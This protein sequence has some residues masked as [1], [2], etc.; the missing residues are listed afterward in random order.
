MNEKFEQLLRVLEQ[1][2][3][4]SG[5]EPPIPEDGQQVGACVNGR[6]VEVLSR[7]I[8]VLTQ[9]LSERSCASSTPSEV[10]VEQVETVWAS[11]ATASACIV[12]SPTSQDASSHSTRASTVENVSPMSSAQASA[13]AAASLGVAST[14]ANGSSIPT[15]HMGVPVHGGT[16]MVMPP[17]F[18]L[19][20][21]LPTGAPGAP[22]NPSSQPIF[23]A[24]P[25]YVPGQG[26]LC[27]GSETNP[28]P[29]PSQVQV[30]QP[31]APPTQPASEELKEIST[32][33]SSG[34]ELAKEGWPTPGVSFSPM[35]L[36]MPQFVSRTL[37]AEGDEKPTHAMC[38]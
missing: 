18:A 37:A 6:R 10:A 24:V 8:R 25:M 22:P 30:V 32:P 26:V 17:G 19:P 13:A 2:E 11:P 1:A 27:A 5:L 15:V 9:L 36:Q 33:A 35:I 4:T 14:S 12:E 31:S 23:I 29:S 16:A 34:S 3:T 28:L 7:T 20:H 21:G 38:A